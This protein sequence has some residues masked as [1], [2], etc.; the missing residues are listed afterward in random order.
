MNMKANLILAALVAL[1]ALSTVSQAADKKLTCLLAAT[2]FEDDQGGTI[3]L[4]EASKP[5]GADG[6]AEVSLGGG[7]VALEVDIHE[8]RVGLMLV[9]NGADGQQSEFA[10]DWPANGGQFYM[11]LGHV[12]VNAQGRRGALQLTCARQDD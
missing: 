12:T 9:N 4:D 1:P 11:A 2:A 3:G 5:I 8:N 7:G 10:T 6:R